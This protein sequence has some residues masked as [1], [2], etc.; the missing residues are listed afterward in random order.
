[1][2]IALQMPTFACVAAGDLSRHVAQAGN[3]D[4]PLVMLLHG[5][6]KFRCG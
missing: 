2:T 5:F 4:G 3:A 6:L 1:M